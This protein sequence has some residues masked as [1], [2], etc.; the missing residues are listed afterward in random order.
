M[1]YRHS[2][3]ED[4]VNGGWVYRKQHDDHLDV[5]DTTGARI[6]EK[7]TPATEKQPQTGDYATQQKGGLKVVRP[8][9]A[10]LSAAG[11]C[12]LSLLTHPFNPLLINTL[13]YLVE[14]TPSSDP[15]PVNRNCSC[16][17]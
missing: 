5:V 1:V 2:G 12:F 7:G 15:H 10:F 3:T 16:W 14:T 9:S 17:K 4:K 11:G 6:L 8:L 13:V